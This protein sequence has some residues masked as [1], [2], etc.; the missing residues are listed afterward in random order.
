MVEKLFDILNKCEGWFIIY[1]FYFFK[2]GFV[3]DGCL[4][5]YKL[6]YIGRY[7]IM[8]ESLNEL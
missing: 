2:F 5:V 7:D 8:R 1:F 6:Y 3:F 4:Y